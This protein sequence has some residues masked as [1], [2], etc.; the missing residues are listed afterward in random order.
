MITEDESRRVKG[1]DLGE[2]LDIR[3]SKCSNSLYRDIIGSST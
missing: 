2:D 1:S 3:A